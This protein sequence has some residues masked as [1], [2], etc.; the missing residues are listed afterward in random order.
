MYKFQ[1]R[2]MVKTHKV[3]G[4][5]AFKA[6]VEELAGSGADVFVMFS[7]SKNAEGVSWCPDCVEAEPVVNVSCLVVY[8]CTIEILLRVASGPKMIINGFFSQF[9]YDGGGMNIDVVLS[10]GSQFNLVALSNLGPCCG[11]YLN[12]WKLRNVFSIKPIF[13]YRS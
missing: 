13:S 1:K 3:E 9:V 10:I 11:C 5:D 12:R 7:G 6:K 2:I 4:F 8:Y